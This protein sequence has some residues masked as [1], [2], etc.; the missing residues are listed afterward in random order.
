MALVVVIALV[1]LDID[2]DNRHQ[3]ALVG[4]SF[5]LPLTLQFTVEIPTVEET[6]QTVLEGEP[7][8]FP[9]LI[10]DALLCRLALRDVVWG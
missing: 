2:Y 7:R 1:G 6:C 5:P 10:R 3:T 8:Q 4:P 9:S